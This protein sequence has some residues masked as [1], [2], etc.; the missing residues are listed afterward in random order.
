MESTI[1]KYL[2]ENWPS[3][4]MLIILVYMAWTISRLFTKWE[5]RNEQRHKSTENRLD[6][7]DGRIDALEF[8]VS[9]IREDV[10]A[11]KAFLIGKH[12]NS[13][14][15]FSLKRSP[16]RLNENGE[17]LFEYIG[18]KA[19]LSGNKDF[20][21]SKIDE[22]KP[23]T[24]LDVEVNANAVCAENMGSNIFND[25]KS[26]V[27]NMPIYTIK[28]ADGNERPYDV[29]MSDVCFVLSL[30]LRDMYLDEH[31]EIPR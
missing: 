28:D 31:P 12:K 6:R 17:R 14:E 30:P 10:L 22:K 29:A 18:G 23:Q 11:I 7:V 21:F 26:T 5:D 20:L 3:A 15:L 4:A 9:E 13:A 2:L 8:K 19:F 1:I 25:I 24:A 16:R 27:Y